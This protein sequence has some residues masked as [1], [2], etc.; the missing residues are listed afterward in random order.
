MGFESPCERLRKSRKRRGDC[1]Y[2]KNGIHR[3]QLT[4]V[5]YLSNPGDPVGQ[6]VTMIIAVNETFPELFRLYL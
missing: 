1:P 3:I 6:F 5:W 2:N 4:C